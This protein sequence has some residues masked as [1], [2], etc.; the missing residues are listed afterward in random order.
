MAQELEGEWVMGWPDR[1]RARIMP[2]KDAEGRTIY[3][4]SPVLDLEGMLTPTDA[5]YIIAQLNMPDPVHPD[6]FSF[7][8]DGMVDSPTQYT[9]EEIRKLPGRTVRAVTEC[10]GNDGEFFDYIKP[11]S[12]MK[13]PSLRVVQAEE[14]GW[15]Q[16]M[17]SDETPDIED[18]RQ[19]IPST[20]LVSGGEWTGVQL[21]SVLERAAIQEGAVCVALHG[22]DE[23]KPDPVTQYHRVGGMSARD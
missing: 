17:D 5:Y 20:G 23:G 11:G 22:W 3:A 16:A 14:G 15:R 2:S 6:D 9:L 7:S 4:R 13:K 19:S 18:I 1:K 10:A 12:N 21:R 8:I